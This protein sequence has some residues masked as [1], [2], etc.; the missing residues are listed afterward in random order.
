MNSFQKAL[1][2]ASNPKPKK[3][4]DQ[5]CFEKKCEISNKL[6]FGF[7]NQVDMMQ[8][9]PASLTIRSDV[10]MP[11]STRN[12]GFIIRHLL[13]QFCR[14]NLQNVDYHNL[15]DFSIAYLYVC[16]ILAAIILQKNVGHHDGFKLP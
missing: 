9:I 11:V 5:Q 3:I 8:R 2:A 16:L 15:C 10:I 1:L 13:R 4:H 7:K 14:L 6:F 12:I